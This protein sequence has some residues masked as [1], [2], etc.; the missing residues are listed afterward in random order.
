[1]FKRLRNA[2]TAVT[3]RG[4]A[5]KPQGEEA[6]EKLGHRNYVGGMWEEIGK[7][8]FD[9]LSSRGSSLRIVFWTSDAAPL[10]E[11]SSSSITWTPAITWDRQRESAYGPRHRERAGK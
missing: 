2:F 8:Q 3:G 6:V 9:F 1:M 5:L 4:C 11:G 7:L 10:E